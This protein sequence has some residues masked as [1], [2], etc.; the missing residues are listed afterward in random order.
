MATNFSDYGIEIPF[1]RTVGQVKCKCPKCKDRRT[2]KRDKSLSV[3]LDKGVWHCHYCNWS[4]YLENYHR[5]DF[6]PKKTYS[7]PSTIPQANYSEKMLSYF[8]SRGLSE[9]T[10]KRCKVGEGLELM[11]P[12]PKSISDQWQQRNTIQF[13]YYCEGELVNIKYRTSDKVFKLVKDAELIPYNIDAIKDK[14]ECIITEG[15]FDCLSFIEAGYTNCI[16]VPNGANNNLNY[17]DD[18]ID[19]WFEDKETI[20]IAV[21]TDECGK[22]L[23]QEL[24]RRF[25]AERCKIVTYGDGCK[26]ANEHIVKYGRESLRMRVEQAEDVHISGI[27]TLSDY[28]EDLD[29]LLETGLKQGA[30]IGHKFFDE[31]ISFETKRLAVVTG[32]PSSGKSE[33]LD[34]ICTRLCLL[35]GWRTAYFSPE[36]MPLSYHASKLI[37]KI[38]GKAFDKSK[39]SQDEY[40]E[41]KSFIKDNFFHILPEE[42]YTLDSILELAKMQVRRKGIKILVIDPYNRLESQQGSKSET[43]Y[44]SEILDKL[45]NFAQ[46]QDVLIFLM[47]HPRKV[48][49]EVG[50]PR[51]PS[52]YDINGSA[53]FYNKADYGIVVHRHK[54]DTEDAN[55]VQVNVDKVKFNHLGQGGECFFKFHA[56]C[57][58]YVDYDKTGGQ[59]DSFKWDSRNYLHCNLRED[60]ASLIDVRK[61]IYDEDLL[62]RINEFNQKNNEVPF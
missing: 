60:P 15:E 40:E 52:L 45:T 12:S 56:S 3:N 43:Q 34:E 1:R 53:N 25:G 14:T 13:C 61:D 44:I 2:N 24:I 55:Y 49:N 20:Y 58:R 41:A 59:S 57:G 38:T 5:K 47:A 50:K 30:T 22:V 26:D 17:L 8:I 62:N 11:P 23:Q 31:A 54:G 29:A 37:R 48:Q 36:N 9:A 18:F 39:V 33:F 28:E 6:V 32:V 10:M 16:S 19:G 27:F 51:I 46:Q 35:Y 7:R 42:G 4:G 21:D